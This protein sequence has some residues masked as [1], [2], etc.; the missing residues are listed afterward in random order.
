M[1][2]VD[3]E[4][5]HRRGLA[6]FRLMPTPP[7]T[8]KQKRACE[9]F[10]LHLKPLHSFISV[11]CQYYQSDSVECQTLG[12]TGSIK[13]CDEG[14]PLY[15]VRVYALDTHWAFS[16]RAGN[17]ISWRRRN[18]NGGDPMN[19]YNHLHKHHCGIDLHARSSYVYIQN[20]AGNIL[21]HKECQSNPESLMALIH[22]PV[23]T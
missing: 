5:C 14:A 9:Q 1:Q 12:V 2:T 13:W 21:L 20:S 19:F 23:I 10:R 17:P 15:G 11:S 22:I 8:A 6:L 7:A 3:T 18:Q 16:L 4:P